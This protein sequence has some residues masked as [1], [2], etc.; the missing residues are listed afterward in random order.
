MLDSKCFTCDQSDTVDDAV[1]FFSLN[2]NARIPVTVS[3]RG[4]PVVQFSVD[5]SDGIK[6]VL[7]LI[8]QDYPNRLNQKVGSYQ[9][10][11]NLYLKAILEP[12]SDRFIENIL[13]PA[14]TRS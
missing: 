4:N 7:D 1:K 12:V 3:K 11:S 8:Q 5:S 2:P 9:V 13:E 10:E 6:F 14:F